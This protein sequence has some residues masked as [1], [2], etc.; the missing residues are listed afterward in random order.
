MPAT[1]DHFAVI[2]KCGKTISDALKLLLEEKHL[3]QY[4]SVNSFSP[5]ID[6]ML[7]DTSEY[8]ALRLE[9]FKAIAGRWYAVQETY[10]PQLP[11]RGTHY[12]GQ[13]TLTFTA[14]R[15]RLYCAPCKRVEPHSC[16]HPDSDDRSFFLVYTCLSCTKAR[17]TFLLERERAA[18]DPERLRL[19]GRHP[20]EYAEPPHS[21]PPFL[22]H[23]YS[24]AVIASNCGFTLMG[25]FGLRTVI[26]Q[27]ARLA[28]GITG[29]I[30]GV[31][32]FE[33]YMARLP[34]GFSSM[35]PSLGALY[36]DLSDDM[37]GAIG[38][39]ALF[40]RAVRKIDSHF[41]ALHSLQTLDPALSGLLSKKR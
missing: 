39:A 27:W 1:Y 22:G 32:L 8:G 16:T 19:S 37:H 40:Q 7:P 11:P 2:D 31:E 21:V 34:V 20:M 41:G 23:Y 4:V 38:D 29:K 5:I 26:E 28:T 14:P 12:S 36:S 9:V 6:E 17:I 33:K 30:D 3:Y 25:L 35:H 10:D 13:G 18:S 15:V 24:D